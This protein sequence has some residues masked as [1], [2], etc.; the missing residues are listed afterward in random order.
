VG[1]FSDTNSEQSVAIFENLGFIL[2]LSNNLA[3][4]QE[5]PREGVK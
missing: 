2:D 5:E 1:Q 4:F 3:G